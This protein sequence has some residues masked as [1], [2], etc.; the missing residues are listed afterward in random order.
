MTPTNP[1][2]PIPPHHPK[3]T[4]PLQ[5]PPTAVPPLP[6]RTR[7]HLPLSRRP[8]PHP[9]PPPPKTHRRT[10]TSTNAK[11]LCPRPQIQ[12][13]AFTPLKIRNEVTPPTR[14]HPLQTSPALK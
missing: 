9:P 3:R 14:S 4:P 1:Q 12:T 6:R 8:S 5:P 11:S 10:A 13:R 7:K 2:S